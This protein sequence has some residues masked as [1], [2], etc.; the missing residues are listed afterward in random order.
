MRDSPFDGAVK[1]AP[2]NAPEAEGKPRGPKREEFLTGSEMLGKLLLY[3][4]ISSFLFGCYF[5]IAFGVALTGNGIE[6]AT[7]ALQQRAADA[8][9]KTE[10]LEKLKSNCHD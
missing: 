1:Q 9:A 2:C 5:G 8:Q 7:K 10:K 4:G 6:K 3:V